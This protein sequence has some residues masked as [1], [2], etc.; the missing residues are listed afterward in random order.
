[1]VYTNLQTDTKLETTFIE[2]TVI[3][4]R[5]IIVQGQV[6]GR[7]RRVDRS[8]NGQMELRSPQ[9]YLSLQPIVLHNTGIAGMTS[10]K[11][12]Q[13]VSHDP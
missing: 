9:G 4:W 5:K 2:E 11:G 1:M 3:A 13:T 12:S 10:S 8:C 6:D 7:R